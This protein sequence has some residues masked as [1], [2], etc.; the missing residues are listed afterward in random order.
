MILRPPRLIGVEVVVPALYVALM[1]AIAW[2]SHEP[3]GFVALFLLSFVSWLFLPPG[4]RRVY[5]TLPIPRQE[6]GRMMWVFCVLVGGLPLTLS[7]FVRTS[8]QLNIG[9]IHLEFVSPAPSL[10]LLCAG[11]TA[12]GTATAFAVSPFQAEIPSLRWLRRRQITLFLTILATAVTVVARPRGL[13]LTSQVALV[14]PMTLLA[15]HTA[16]LTYR[17][18]DLIGAAFIRAARHVSTKRGMGDEVEWLHLQ[19]SGRLW[20]T[21]GRA[22]F[23]FLGTAAV[24]MVLGEF[25]GETVVKQAALLLLCYY[26][27]LETGQSGP[28]RLSI[29]HRVFMIVPGAVIFLALVGKF[30]R[31]AAARYSISIAIACCFL[32]SRDNVHLA[33]RAIRTL[34]L[35][36]LRIVTRCLKRGLVILIA[37][38]LAAS[39]TL[40]YGNRPDIFLQLLP[41][42]LSAYSIGILV[43]PLCL[44]LQSRV[45]AYTFL[46]LPALVYLI[47]RY[48]PMWALALDALL[49]ALAIPLFFRTL[50]RSSRIYRRPP[51]KGQG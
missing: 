11:I 51:Q 37:A 27:S 45:G 14:F 26:A 6:L 4:V 1:A 3:G 32:I 38:I 24:C 2:F 28:Y 13:G 46:A 48:S 25:L 35:D 16:F 33:V 29:F 39:V 41:A 21:A 18:A 30:P 50:E 15:I 40:L 12:A 7:S 9:A 44:W 20:S 5:A 22:F 47:A 17:N 42:I 49:L 8:L 34:P 36:P 19:D 10:L 43:Q 23:L 31:D